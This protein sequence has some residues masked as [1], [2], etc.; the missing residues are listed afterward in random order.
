MRWLLLLLPIMASGCGLFRQNCNP[1]DV[2]DM[3][4]VEIDG[5]SWSSSLYKLTL[6]GGGET[7]VCVD[8]RR[9][10]SDTGDP[11]IPLELDCTG[12]SSVGFGDPNPL[13]GLRID[14]FAP[15]AFTLSLTEDGVLLIE[16][17]YAPDYALSNPTGCGAAD[18]REATVRLS[19]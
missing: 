15:D 3:L 17:N 6:E 11:L 4:F 19:L 12:A 13:D 10:D 2:P 1:I 16:E 8:D 7:I 9:L 18:Q 14:D 5:V